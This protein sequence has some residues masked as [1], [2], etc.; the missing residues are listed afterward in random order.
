[1]RRSGSRVHAVGLDPIVGLLHSDTPARDA[2]VFDLME[3]SR[4]L[5]PRFVTSREAMFVNWR[6]T[7]DRIAER[8]G[9]KCG[10]IRTG[11]LGIPTAR[12]GSRQDAGAP[13]SSFTVSRELGHGSETMVKDIYSH[14]GTVRH[15]SEVVEYRIDQHCHLDAVRRRLKS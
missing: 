10:E 2:L 5:F 9:W 7:L 13:I 12:L 11:S 8:A 6:R 4:V 3:L 15:R 1:M 14:L